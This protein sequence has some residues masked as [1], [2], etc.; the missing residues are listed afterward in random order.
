LEEPAEIQFAVVGATNAVAAWLP[1]TMMTSLVTCAAAA[2]ATL[3]AWLAAMVQVP[4]VT[5]VTVE[6][7]VPLT[8]H[9]LGVLL[10]KMTGLPESP[11]VAVTVPV[12]PTATVGAVPTVMV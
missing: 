9:T 11:P 10:L 4:T 7:L 6:P 3:P 8:V 12:P 5:P 1:L 2:K